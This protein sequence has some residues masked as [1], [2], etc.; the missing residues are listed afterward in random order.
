MQKLKYTNQNIYD[1]LNDN[2]H[3]VDWKKKSYFMGK[4]VD[5]SAAIKEKQIYKTQKQKPNIKYQTQ[6]CLGCKKSFSLL[7]EKNPLDAKFYNRY[8]LCFDC[9]IDFQSKLR[10]LNIW[11]SYQK[12]YM[13]ANM[14][15][16]IRDSIQWYEQLMNTTQWQQLINSHGQT[17]HIQIPNKQQYT[18]QIQTIIDELI[19]YKKQR[20]VQYIQNTTYFI[21]KFDEYQ[22]Q[23]KIDTYIQCPINRR[24]NMRQFE[25][26]YERSRIQQ[27]VGDYMKNEIDQ[28]AIG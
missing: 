12:S 16:T 9:A 8:K 1:I 23:G 10:F 20:I 17:E 5:E 22:S 14:L 6:A 27:N 3:A 7:N 4:T 2:P 21:Q 26:K 13:L 19:E 28:A 11:Q 25:S 24:L 15:S 18:S